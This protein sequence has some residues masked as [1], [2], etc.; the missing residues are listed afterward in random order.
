MASDSAMRILWLQQYFGTPAGWGS[1]RQ[2]EFAKRWVAAGHSVDVV[3]SSAYDP[4]LAEAGGEV[5][6]IR[7][8]LS[9]AVYRPQMGFARR[10]VSFLRFMFDAFWHVTRYG[11]RL[12]DVLNASSGPLTNV[13]PALWGRLLYG[14]PSYSR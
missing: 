12:Y 10:V 7:L 8:Y 3:C 9:G 1:Q 6:G 14:L 11:R 5:D 13:V 2:Y 4:S